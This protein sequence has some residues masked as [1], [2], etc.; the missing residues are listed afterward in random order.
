MELSLPS[1]ATS[2]DLLSLMHAFTEASQTTIEEA[3]RM[4]RAFLLYLTSTTLD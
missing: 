2:D 3:T 1:G 4:A